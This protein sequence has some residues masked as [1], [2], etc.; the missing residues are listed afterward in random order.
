MGH[1]SSKQL[2]IREI[3]YGTMSEREFSSFLQML[4][5]EFDERL[6]FKKPTH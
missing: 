6:D 4:K 3:T 2:R 5:T 1:L